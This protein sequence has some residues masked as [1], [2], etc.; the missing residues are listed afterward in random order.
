M[1]PSDPQPTFAPRDAAQVVFL[2]MTVILTCSLLLS[3]FAL[4]DVAS[5]LI[6]MVLMQAAMF[7]GIAWVVR[8]RNFSWIQTF[9]LQRERLPRAFALGAIG[10]VAL[11]PILGFIS[12]LWRQILTYAGLPPDDQL[13]IQWLTARKEPLVRIVFF[14]EAT[15]IAPVIEELFFRGFLEQAF[16]QRHGAIGTALLCALLFAAFHAHLPSLLPLFAIAL[17]FSAVY[18]ATR[19]LAAAIVMHAAYN[20]VNFVWILLAPPT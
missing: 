3:F 15:L 8:S 5:G 19:S 2:V 4:P 14:L 10:C 17:G 7:G 9:G 13:A 20:T 16:R 12:L 1:P 18:H 6:G 11:I